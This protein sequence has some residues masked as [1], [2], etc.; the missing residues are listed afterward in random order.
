MRSKRYFAENIRSAVQVVRQELGPNAIILAHQRLASGVEVTAVAGKEDL[1]AIDGLPVGET[2][3]ETLEV[4]GIK[5][6]RDSYD[7][8]FKDSIAFFN[9]GSDEGQIN[10]ECG[11]VHSAV[12]GAI[13]NNEVAY[14][15]KLYSAGDTEMHDKTTR[16]SQQSSGKD[17]PK[18]SSV[19]VEYDFEAEM[20]MIL[21]THYV[22]LHSDQHLVE[23]KTNPQPTQLKEAKSEKTKQAV[24][25]TKK[26]SAKRKNSQSKVHTALSKLNI[27]PEE[28][29]VVIRSSKPSLPENVVPPMLSKSRDHDILV[30]SIELQIGERAYGDSAKKSPIKA[31]LMGL[32]F[33]E[34]PYAQD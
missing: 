25:K 32:F 16:N 24:A 5:E 2:L 8:S 11:A 14:R 4:L 21:N 29:Q 22:S 17:K 9:S 33:A 18:D 28:K 27:Q 20:N 26:Q 23:S 6:V 3:K 34:S 10:A 31:A 19:S 15:G 1:L 13:E 30:E 7:V 12:A